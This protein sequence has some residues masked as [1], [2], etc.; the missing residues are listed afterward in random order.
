MKVFHQFYCIAGNNLATLNSALVVWIP[1]KD[2]AA[3]VSDYRPISLVHSIAKLITK[4]LS[5]RLSSVIDSII[6][7]AQSAFLA[8]KSTHD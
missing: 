2:G 5:M 7:L 6:S 8:K 3:T 1:K 4:V